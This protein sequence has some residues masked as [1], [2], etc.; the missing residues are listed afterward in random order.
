[1]GDDV[2]YDLSV[3]FSQ[4]A[5]GAELAVPTPEGGSSSVEVRPG[6]QS[7]TV[8]PVRGKGLPSISNGRRGDLL[9][10]LNVWTPPTLTAEQEELFRRLAMVEGKPPQEDGAGRR[11]WNRMKEAL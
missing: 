5:L 11:L 4:A 6:T 8:L 10:R 2:I 9:V 1:N 7:G 3:S